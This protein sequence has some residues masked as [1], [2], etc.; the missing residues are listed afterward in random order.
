MDDGAWGSAAPDFK[1]APA[2]QSSKPEDIDGAWG[3]GL[4]D[5]SPE[6]E[7]AAQSPTFAERAK[8]AFNPSSY[9]PTRPGDLM[10]YREVPPPDRSKQSIPE[11][12]RNVSQ[13]AT[14]TS[15]GEGP[16]SVEVGGKAVPGL[17]VGAA[18]PTALE[19]TIIAAPWLARGA[20]AA[21]KQLPGTALAATAGYVASQ[22]A[23][24]PEWM[25][26]FVHNLLLHF[27]LGAGGK[28]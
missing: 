16:G 11:M 20:V 17:M 18:L 8:D 5:H 22:F 6:T 15:L 14:N 3:A 24:Q 27:Q 10:R 1:S 2:A 19:G 4:P 7:A 25:K 9:R 21:G 23:D 28:K 13:R 26:E 12:M